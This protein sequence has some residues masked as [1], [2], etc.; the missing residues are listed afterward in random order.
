M[1]YKPERI[2]YLI[3][4]LVIYV[5]IWKFVSFEA[6]VGTL[7]IIIAARDKVREC[8]LYFGDE[9]YRAVSSR[10]NS[11]ADFRGFDSPN[12]RPLYV[13]DG[14]GIKSTW[15]ARTEKDVVE[16]KKRI[17]IDLRND[18]SKGIAMIHIVPGLEVETLMAVAEKKST[19]AIILISLGLGIIPSLEGE[20]NLA[21][22]V[23]KIIK[24]LNKPVI[25]ASSFVGGDTNMDVYAVSAPTKA[26]GAID[27]G[28]M[29]KE[30]VLVKARLILAQDEFSHSLESFEKAFRADF[31]GETHSF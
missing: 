7:L 26:A 22:P 13:T 1:K 9:A 30:A 4:Y 15:P 5:G 29:T 20:Y 24:D 3:L 18:F 11:E 17:G 31:A 25:I 10:K 23:E 27:S 2:I 6:A 16:S 8:I 19:K 28:K 12:V 14:L 21:K